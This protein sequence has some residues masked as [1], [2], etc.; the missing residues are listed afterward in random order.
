M[1]ASA[2]PDRSTTYQLLRQH[3]IAMSEGGREREATTAPAAVDARVDRRFTALR[4]ATGDRVGGLTVT[5]SA[6]GAV[7]GINGSVVLITASAALPVAPLASADGPGTA[8]A[9]NG[10]ND[11]TTTAV[12]DT[13]GGGCTD[14]RADG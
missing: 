14:G 5:S 10:V 8:V 4:V 11:S 13:T 3:Q 6:T 12:L 7:V 9:G 1:H 2:S